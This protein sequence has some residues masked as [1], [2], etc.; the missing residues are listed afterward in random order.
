MHC[1]RPFCTQ[2][3]DGAA[4]QVAAVTMGHIVTRQAGCRYRRGKCQ[5][6]GVSRQRHDTADWGSA[7]A[8]SHK[9]QQVQHQ[10]VAKHVRGLVNPPA[11]FTCPGAASNLTGG[12]GYSLVCTRKGRILSLNSLLC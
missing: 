4:R 7:V 5:S 6:C 1:C 9:L 8:C 10:H 3:G 2:A 12:G 11:C